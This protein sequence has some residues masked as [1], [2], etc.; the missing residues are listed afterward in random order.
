M[1]NTCKE[2]AN[3]D[4]SKLELV[5]VSAKDLIDKSDEEIVQATLAELNKLFPHHSGEE[6]P[7]KLLKSHVVKTPRSVYTAILGRQQCRPSQ[8]TPISNFY[9]SGNYIM[10]SYLGSMEGVVLSG[11]LTAQ[12]IAQGQPPQTNSQ[13][14]PLQTRTPATNAATA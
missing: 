13:S 12:A 14:L 2:Y 7:A 1:S 3:P 9:L 11:K 8:I 4:H 5:L 6:N 10:Q